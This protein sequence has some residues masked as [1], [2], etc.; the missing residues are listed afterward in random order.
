VR[1]ILAADPVPFPADLGREFDAII[2]AAAEEA[3]AN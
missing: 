1:E 3:A 2:A